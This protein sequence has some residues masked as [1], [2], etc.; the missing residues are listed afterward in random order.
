MRW[1]TK[2]TAFSIVASHI[3]PRPGPHRAS[4]VSVPGLAGRWHGPS[5]GAERLARRLTQ[6]A[7]ETIPDALDEGSARRVAAATAA[8]A[9]PRG[10]ESKSARGSQ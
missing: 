10:V 3:S 6:A 8:A 7:A 9:A 4:Q 2:S 5:T 1:Q